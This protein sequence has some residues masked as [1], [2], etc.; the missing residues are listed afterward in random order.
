MLQ[1]VETADRPNVFR[2]THPNGVTFADLYME[3]DG[4][5][6]CSFDTGGGFL[7]AW[8]LRCISDKLDALN[9]EWKRQIDAHFAEELAREMLSFSEQLDRAFD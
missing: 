8:V 9:A 3:I 6:V 7:D 5:Y 2:V 4:F 1:F